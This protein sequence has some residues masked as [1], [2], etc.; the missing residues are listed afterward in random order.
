M[1]TENTGLNVPPFLASELCPTVDLT[2]PAEVA[3]RPDQLS[4]ILYD[5]TEYD[6]INMRL[7][8]TSAIS[9]VAGLKM[10]IHDNNYLKRLRG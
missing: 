8:A 10:V 6:L 9:M 3:H 5:D 4:K 7:N 2:V 1:N